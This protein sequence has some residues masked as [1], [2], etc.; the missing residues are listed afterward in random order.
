MP[1]DPK[2]AKIRAVLDARRSQHLYR[3]TLLADSPQQP[4]MTINGQAMLT[5]CS[6]DYLGLANHPDV[7]RAFQQAANT[8]GVGSGA[9]HLVNGH[10][11]SYTHLD[12]YKR[13]R[14]SRNKKR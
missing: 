10:S 6:N 9:A 11:V 2:F 13:Q 7:I 4:H 5:F 3:R 12:V 1:S 14:F 8:Y